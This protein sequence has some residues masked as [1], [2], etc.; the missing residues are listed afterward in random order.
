[1]TTE[2][3]FRIAASNPAQAVQDLG[4]AME[5]LAADKNLRRKMGEMERERVSREFT[6][7][8][9]G[10]VLSAYYN[11]ILNPQGLNIP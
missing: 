8:H 3:G 6:W 5:K 4:R 11:E 2:T 7:E 9:K 1:V 10:A